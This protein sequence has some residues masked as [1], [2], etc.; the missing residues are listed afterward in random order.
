MKKSSKLLRTLGILVLCMAMLF[1]TVAC[2]GGGASSDL[3]YGDDD[4]IDIGDDDDDTVIVTSSDSSG[5]GNAV[6]HEGLEQN[7][8]T[9]ENK[10]KDFL[11]SVPK[12]LKGQ[13]VTILIFWPPFDYEIAKMDKFTKETGIKVKFINASTH[14]MYMQKLSA[15][16]AQGNSPDIAAVMSPSFPYAII[17]DYFMPLSKTGLDYSKDIYDKQ[18]MDYFK[19]QGEHYG[20]VIKGNTHVTLGLLSYNADIFSKYGIT[21]PYT[22]W[23]KGTWNWDQFI[24]T[25][26]EVLQKSN[27]SVSACGSEYTAFRLPMTCGEDAVKLLNGKLV[28]NLSSTK[29]RSAY[30]QVANMTTLGQYKL[31]DANVHRQDFMAGKCAMYL[32]ESWAYQKGERYGDL[33]FA[34]GYAP[35]PSEDGKVRVSADVQL[36]GIPQGAD[37]VE[38]ATYALEYWLS[39]IYDEANSYMWLN[40]SVGGFMD[41]LWEQEKVYR[42]SEG[43][44][45]YGGDYVWHDFSGQMMKAGVNLDSVADRWSAVVDA[46][47]KKIYDHAK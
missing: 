20:V 8:A 30:K 38:A 29:Y 26:Q 9:D 31:I 6:E 5:S 1:T 27:S 42:I 40:K 34:L 3:N 4:A 7:Y 23:Q 32:D 15:Y 22:H 39:P 21:D 37:N 18:S 47:I 44:M 19:W 33:P 45:E 46:N 43:T 11:A 41:W 13:E 24:K 28:N 2:G 14:E 12:S 25:G 16:K 10:K 36:W 35:M 17:Q